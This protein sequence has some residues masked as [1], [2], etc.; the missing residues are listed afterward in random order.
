[1][2]NV[3]V[4]WRWLVRSFSTVLG[5]DQR[6][7]WRE[8]SWTWKSPFIFLCRLIYPYHLFSNEPENH[9]EGRRKR[10][11]KEEEINENIWKKEV[12]ENNCT[13][14]FKWW[15]CVCVCMPIW[16]PGIYKEEWM[17]MND[18]WC[19]MYDYDEWCIMWGYIY[20]VMNHTCLWRTY[21]T[22]IGKTVLKQWW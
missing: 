15:W 21:V 19:M 16:K 7:F 12:K 6:V 20:E 10:K 9:P 8:R 14:G 11:K 22:Q 18:E 4:N 5:A 17:M 13:H 3:F 1:M 2:K